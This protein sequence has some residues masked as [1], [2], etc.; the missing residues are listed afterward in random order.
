MYIISTLNVNKY[1][2]IQ[3]KK[4]KIRFYNIKFEFEL[5]KA[6]VIFDLFSKRI[7]VLLKIH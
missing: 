6:R 3:R 5:E 7:Q 2:L 4:F 1:N